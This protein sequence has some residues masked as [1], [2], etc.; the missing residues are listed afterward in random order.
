MRSFLL[1]VFLG[2]VLTACT[3]PTAPTPDPARDP[4]ASVLP[5][6]PRVGQNLT[7]DLQANGM[8]GHVAL[9]VEAPDGSVQQLLPNRLPGGAVELAHSGRTSFPAADSAFRLVASAPTG[10][11][12]VLVYLSAAPLNLA[13]ISAYANA[14]SAFATVQTQGAGALVTTLLPKLTAQNPGRAG[15]GTFTVLP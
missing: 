1:V 9:F 10:D 13:G 6:T 7:F 5:A 14:N 11:H 12:Q 8:Q 2:A 3:P 4:S 15:L